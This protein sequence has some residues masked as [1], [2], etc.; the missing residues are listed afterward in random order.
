M[1]NF[2]HRFLSNA[3]QI[4]QPLQKLIAI[5]ATKRS[6]IKL[7]RSSEA[8]SAFMAAKEALVSATLLTYPKPNTLMSI[9]CDALD[10]AEGAAYARRSHSMQCRCYGDSV[11]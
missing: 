4:L 7:Q 8:T 9:M 6:S 11:L 2:H 5:G 1:V 10:S 3:A